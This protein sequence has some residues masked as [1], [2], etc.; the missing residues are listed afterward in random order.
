MYDG[1]MA[2]DDDDES[3]L[4]CLLLRTGSDVVVTKVDDDDVGMDV[5]VDV[6]ENNDVVDDMSDA[7]AVEVMAFVM[8]A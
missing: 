5:D 8:A 3:D 4:R 2:G 1:D 7:V 6:N